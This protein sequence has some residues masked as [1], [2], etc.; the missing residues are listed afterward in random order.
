MALLQKQEKDV[1]F[2]LGNLIGNLELGI[3]N[4]SVVRR[5]SVLEEK[6]KDILQKLHEEEKANPILTRDQITSF[7]RQLKPDDITDI[8]QKRK[9]INALLNRA[10]LIDNK[11]NL[12]FNYKQQHK[13]TSIDDLMNS[14]KESVG[15]PS[16]ILCCPN[17]H[18]T[19]RK[20]CFAVRGKGTRNSDAFLLFTE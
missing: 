2:R 3:A 18:L 5:I 14:P 15:S 11:L 13:V 9:L 20:G 19:G 6:E 17:S 8:K 12:Y 7:L 1:Q 10:V 4:E 16:D